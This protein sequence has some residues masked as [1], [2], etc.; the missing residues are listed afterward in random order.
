MISNIF[1]KSYPTL[2]CSFFDASIYSEDNN[3]EGIKDF[4]FILVLFDRYSPKDFHK[5]NFWAN[6]YEITNQISFLD[7]RMGYIY[8]VNQPKFTACYNEVEVHL[9]AT[10]K[11]LQEVLIHKEEI[12]NNKNSISPKYSD[13]LIHCAFIA[14]SINSFDSIGFEKN[15]L[16]MINYETLQIEKTKVFK[17]PYCSACN[18]NEEYTHIFL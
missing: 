6:K 7:N 10:V 13:L 18:L 12:I 11:N 1:S 9:E 3:L 15:I 16:T 17:M 2:N 4:D 5:F 14:N 8:P